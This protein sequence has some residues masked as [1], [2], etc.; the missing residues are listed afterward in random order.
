MKK[1]GG[2]GVLCCDFV[3]FNMR[4]KLTHQYFFVCFVYAIKAC[5]S[6]LGIVN[7][8]FFVSFCSL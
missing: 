7:G 4:V 5:T 3:L 1:G 2:K 8:A 6:R